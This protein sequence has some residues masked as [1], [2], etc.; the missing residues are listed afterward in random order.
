M[1]LMRTREPPLVGDDEVVELFRR[2]EPAEGAEDQLTRALVDPAAGDF[3]VLLA[4]RQ[5]DVLDRQAVGG[6]L[7]GIDDDVHG[8]GATADE[9][10]GADAVDGFQA[11]LDPLAGDLGDFAEVATAGDGDGHDGH[12]VGVELVDDRR[13]GAVGE[14]RTG[15]S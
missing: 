6:E 5:F 4:E 9:V 8:P 14:C 10:D 7:V 3:E 12:R 13:V 15:P 11:F 1:S 2:V